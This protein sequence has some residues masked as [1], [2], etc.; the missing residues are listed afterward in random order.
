M[1]GALGIIAGTAGS[2][3]L[4]FSGDTNTGI[5]SPGG[6]QVAIS[7]NGVQRINIEADGDINIDGGGVFY[8]ATNNRLG[9]GTASA[10]YTLDVNGPIRSDGTSGGLYFGGNSTTPAVGAAIHRPAA[11]TLAFVTASTERARIDSSGRLLVGTSNSTDNIRLNQKIAVVSTGSS[12][13]GGIA[14]TNYGGSSAGVAPVI[15]LKRSAGTTDGD[16]TKVSQ[17]NV[18]GYI[19]WQ[20]ADGAAWSRAAEI[21]AIADGDWTTSGDTSDSPGALVFSTTADG[22]SSPTEQLRITSDRYVRLA[23]GTGG[24]QFGGD[25]AAANALDDYEEG[26]FTPTIVGTSTAGTA[27]YAANGQVGRYTK[28]GNR[29]FFDI[30][31]SWTAHTGTGDLQINGLPFTVQNT[32]NLNRNYSAILNVVAMTAGNLGAAF[33]SPNTTAV[34]LRQ[35]PT[36]GGSVATIPMDTSAQISISGCFE[37]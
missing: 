31:L 2:P 5:Y 13:Y 30:Y 34:A 32:T 9:I 33:S 7:T 26:T 36:G 15:D 37:A 3:G 20:G 35:V 8:D 12:S 23:S 25:T 27:T 21:S 18:L 11:D 1:T 17:N 29:V 6:D 10:G 22:A 19:V 28:I 16:Y 24:I 14:I 4:Y